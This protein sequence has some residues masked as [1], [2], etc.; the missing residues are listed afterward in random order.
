MN[1]RNRFQKLAVLAT[2]LIL[3]A[4][5]QADLITSVTHNSTHTIELGGIL[6][7]GDYYS[8][9]RTQ[10]VYKDDPSDPTL[11]LARELFGKAEFIR[12]AHDARGL[13]D[14]EM[15]V[16][17]SS[18]AIVYLFIDKRV[19]TVATKM[20]WVAEMG[21]V[22]TGETMTFDENNNGTFENPFA[23][24]Q[25]K[26]SA[27]ALVLKHQN[28]GSIN[29]Y[30]VAAVP[31]DPAIG[32][33][34]PSNG[35]VGVALNKVLTWTAPTNADIDPLV[36]IEYRLF[37][38]PNETYVATGNGAQCDYYQNFTAGMLSYDPV[39]DLDLNVTY[40]WRVDVKCQLVGVGEPNTFNGKV[41]TFKAVGPQPVVTAGSNV[42]TSLD[43]LP[44]ALSGTVSDVDN[45]VAVITWN[46]LTDDSVYPGNAVNGGMRTIDRGDYTGDPAYTALLKDWIAADARQQGCDYLKL[47]LSN[48]P[49]GTYTWTSYHH[50]N[51]DQTG[52]FDLTIVDADGTRAP[53]DGRYFE[54]CRY[55]FC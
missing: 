34:S 12:V 27:G 22:N 16:N 39:P 46:I 53:I 35:E 33:P 1:K 31:G 6:D 45:D 10:H 50:D 28:S 49:A 52:I 29:M 9:A 8:P 11:V 7:S 18:S 23:I 20:P 43:L 36:P 3:A 48:L 15:T 38:D 42:L 19:D 41:L 54:W 17:L 5:A 2:A 32:D 40:F 4:V 21:F 37:M 14:Y 26:F 55:C 13:A 44:A 24:Y 47:T 51:N 25:G 30:G